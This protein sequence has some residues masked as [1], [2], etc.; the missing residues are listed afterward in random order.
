MLIKALVA[1]HDILLE[2]LRRLSTGINIE[3]DL[4][5]ILFESDDTKW[6]D[7]PLPA[8]VKS[9]EAEQSLQL[10]DGEEVSVKV[11][12]SD[13]VCCFFVFYTKTYLLNTKIIS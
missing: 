2:D 12:N 5:E 4:T 11:P 9:V 1:A 8:R 10:L 6:F 13:T 3:I 7:S